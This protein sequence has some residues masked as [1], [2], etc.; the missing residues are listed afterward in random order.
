MYCPEMLMLIL[1]SFAENALEVD[2][3]AL[4]DGPAISGD[5]DPAVLARVVVLARVHRAGAD[6]LKKVTEKE[7]N[8]S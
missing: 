4:T 5:A 7:K 6:S 3:P 8:E 1:T 2:V